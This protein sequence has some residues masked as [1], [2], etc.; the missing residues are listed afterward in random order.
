MFYFSDVIGDVCYATEGKARRMAHRRR[1]AELML[2]QDAE[3]VFI[4]SHVKGIHMQ[5]SL[6]YVCTMVPSTVLFRDSGEKLSTL[7]SV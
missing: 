7:L 1:M 5:H 4:S 3:R 6:H 2:T